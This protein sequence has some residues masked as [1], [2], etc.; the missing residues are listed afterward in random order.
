MSQY[1]DK[2]LLDNGP[3]IKFF[4]AVKSLLY[5]STHFVTKRGLTPILPYSATD[6]DAIFTTMINIQDVLKQKKHENGPL[7]S[8][9]GVNHI[10]KKKKKNTALI[11]TKI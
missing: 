2:S 10:A 8:D 5:S 6:Y 9:E 11:S 7:W 1:K 4:A 3:H